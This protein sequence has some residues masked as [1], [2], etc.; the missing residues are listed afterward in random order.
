[1][2]IAALLVSAAALAVVAWVS[3]TAWDVV[4]NGHPA[5]AVALALTALVGLIG[6]IASVRALRR[7][8]PMR[9]E[10]RSVGRTVL[11][12][13][14][15][16]AAVGWVAV[17]AWLKPF[18]AVEPAL[19]ALVS[20]DS[21]E[22]QES[23]TAIVLAPTSTG[24]GVGVVF[25]PGARVDARAYA[26]ILRPLAEQGTLVVIPKQP[27]GIGFL[28]SGALATA[29]DA[30]PEIA[31]WVV[32]GHS[33][34]GTVAASTAEEADGL[35]LYA[36]Y[37]ASDISGLTDL[38]VLSISGSEDGLATPAD[39]EASRDV[40]PPTATFEVVEGATHAFFGD[41]GPQPGDGTPT[42]S[43]DEARSIIGDLS[44]AF[45]ADGTDRWLDAAS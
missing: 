30:H 1:M 33:L 43:H 15:L 11:G 36:A 26:A 24:T 5:Y 29:R 10:R 14:G 22:V 34:G 39:I 23:P 27:F 31:S 6:L 42:I 37:P 21:V 18:A 13:I 25:Q 20:T 28:A 2:K 19:T 32:G 40:L 35:L 9:G 7:P 45:V 4:V 12:V 44:L 8:A 38:D 16:V 3:L 17:L 41:Y